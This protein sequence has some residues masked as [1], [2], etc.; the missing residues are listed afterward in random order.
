[1][2]YYVPKKTTEYAT[3]L[4]LPKRAYLGDFA[5]YPPVLGLQNTFGWFEVRSCGAGVYAVAEPRHEQNGCFYVVLGE[6]KA[7]VFDTGLGIYDPRPL[8]EEL[9]DDR[10]LIIVNSHFHFDHTGG[11]HFFCPREGADGAVAP[12]AH[13]HMDPLVSRIAEQGLHTPIITEQVRDEAFPLGVPEGFDQATYGTEPFLAE[14][15]ADGQVFD[16]GG[17]ELRVMF[18]PGHSPDGICLIDDA[19]D[20]A[21]VGDTFYLGALYGQ[22]ASDEFDYSDMEAYR[23][24]LHR[25][26]GEIG[27]ETKVFC[28]HNEFMADGEKIRQAAE[29]FDQILDGGLEATSATGDQPNYG[30]EGEIRQVFGDGF[31]VM[32]I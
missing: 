25:L 10:Q 7:L 4:D 20:L 5:K 26:A 1:M 3:Y 22:F 12:A 32:Y 6:E 8:V 17:R 27:P 29:L 30:E 24:T 15:V 21:L 18:A 19:H 28:C 23:Q 11:N 14:D 9:A 31:S 16:L 13:I 2:T